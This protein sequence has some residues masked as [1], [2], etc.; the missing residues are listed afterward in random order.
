MELVDEEKLVHVYRA[1]LSSINET[2]I[3]LSTGERIASGAIVFCTGWNI[4][5][6]LLF[7]P[8]EGAGFGV[9]APLDRLSPEYTSYWQKLDAAA[10]KYVL[11]SY[12]LLQNPPKVGMPRSSPPI[13]YRCFRTIAP[14]NLAAK[15][16]RSLI[17]LGMLGNSQVPTHAEVS[18]LWGV[19][20]LEGLLPDG[21]C[22]GLLGDKEAMD[23]DVANMTAFMARR[24]PEKSHPLAPVETQSYIDR[25]ML[26]LGLRID[27]KRV[28]REA[29]EGFL[30]IRG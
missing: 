23:K 26:D 19:A 28:G 29:E 1:T 15:H 17:Y 10:D 24:Y 8:S 7:H 2:T 6:D 12:P 9:S 14:N 25:T 5:C 22:D 11:D 18:S 13:P 21:S 30:G 20:Y 4:G 3:E 16:D 27:R